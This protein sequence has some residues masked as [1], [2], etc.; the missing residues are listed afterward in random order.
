M[1]MRYSVL[2]FCLLLCV[3]CVFAESNK[4][5]EK[6]GDCVFK[7]ITDKGMGTGFFISPDGYILTNYHVVKDAK[8]IKININKKDYNVQ[9]KKTNDDKDI[10]LLKTDTLKNLPCLTMSGDSVE[11][12]E[13]VFAIG[14]PSNEEKTITKGIVSQKSVT[15]NNNRYIKT[16]AV[17]NPGSSGGPLLNDRGDVIGINTFID[18]E[19]KDYG[20]A[21]PIDEVIDFIDCDVVL[22]SNNIK[23]IEESY[24][25][26]EAQDDEN[27]SAEENPVPYGRC[28]NNIWVII[29][30]AVIVLIV[31]AV[32]ILFVVKNRK[33]LAKKSSPTPANTNTDYSDI[34]I[35]LG[36]ETVQKKTEN[37]DDIDIELH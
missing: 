6:A 17:I 16:D 22:Y 27:I 34:N 36:G 25:E 10:A 11:D 29:G 26:A 35:Q 12:T 20:Y 7:V 31:A 37:Y 30:S 2:L 13:E 19:T 15:L 18:A 24:G 23:S 4:A 33:K 14:F 5:I 28:L 8:K 1:R 21:L 9:I 32:I 3:S